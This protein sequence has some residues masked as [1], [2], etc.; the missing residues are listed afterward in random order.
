MTTTTKKIAIGLT[1]GV[2]AYFLVTSFSNKKVELKSK[3]DGDEM[4]SYADGS[5]EEEEYEGNL[6]DAEMSGSDEMMSYAD[7]TLE[8]DEDQLDPFY[9]F[10]SD[11]D[12]GDGEY[13]LIER[14][15]TGSDE[16]MSF[17]DGKKVKKVASAMT[18]NQKQLAHWKKRV[19]ILTKKVD[20]IKTAF[21]KLPMTIKYKAELSRMSPKLVE[22]RKMVSKLQ[23]KK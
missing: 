4:L 10:D 2:V 21:S 18:D 9:D 7:G 16:A 13:L 19:E 5:E 23:A 12:F 14:D 8:S 15:V 17:A 11:Y 6:L 1:L 22:A 20:S 3:F